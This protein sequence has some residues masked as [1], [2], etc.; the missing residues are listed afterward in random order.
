MTLISSTVTRA[1]CGPRVDCAA[2]G[3]IAAFAAALA[4]CGTTERFGKDHKHLAGDI[5]CS[6]SKNN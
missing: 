1:P 4:S 5:E 3:P 2:R 6:A